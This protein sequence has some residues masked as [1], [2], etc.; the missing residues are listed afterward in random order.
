MVMVCSLYDEIYD[1]VRGIPCG[2]VT[3]Y[4]II[5]RCIGSSC[6]ARLVGYAL[7]A[8]RCDLQDIPAHRV[9]NRQGLLTG[10]MYF[11][12]PELMEKLLIAEGINVVNNKVYPLEK[13]I[14]DPMLEL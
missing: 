8:I 14:W 3:T 13:Y 5:A 7:N 10:R 12:P 1:I 2:R 11:N 6:S 4:G 9:V